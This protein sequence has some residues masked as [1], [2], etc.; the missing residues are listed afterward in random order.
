MCA[1]CTS[2]HTYWQR[3]SMSSATGS[4]L[5]VLSPWWMATGMVW[6]LRHRWAC[7]NRKLQ[8]L[9][10]SLRGCLA[11]LGWKFE[12]QRVIMIPDGLTLLHCLK[13]S[14][15]RF[16]FIIESFTLG[17][18]GISPVILILNLFQSQN[19]A[20]IKKRYLLFQSITSTTYF[21]NYWDLGTAVFSDTPSSI[22]L[23]SCM[24][25]HMFYFSRRI[26][27]YVMIQY[28]SCSFS[29]TYSSWTHS[30]CRGKL[31]KCGKKGVVLFLLQLGKE[32]WRLVNKIPFPASNDYLNKLWE[33]EVL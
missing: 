24:C 7:V 28:V 15:S 19:K 26:D 27:S 6:W 12:H 25:V 2:S 4:S 3:D 29:L 10:D 18:L 31:A 30:I 1:G 9:S 5:L 32:E 16:T 23:L 13:S 17:K 22:F 21:V 20:C 11:C 14:L 33:I 8:S